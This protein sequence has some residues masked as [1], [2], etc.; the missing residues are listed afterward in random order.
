METE[1]TNQ[2]VN[3]FDALVDHI[4]RCHL[5][6]LHEVEDVCSDIKIKINARHSRTIDNLLAVKKKIEK[7]MEISMASKAVYIPKDN[8]LKGEKDI[9]L[10]KITE[11]KINTLHKLEMKLFLFIIDNCIIFNKQISSRIY[12]TAIVRCT[13]IPIKNISRQY[14]TLC[15]RNYLTIE[16]EKIRAGAWKILKLSNDIFADRFNIRKYLHLQLL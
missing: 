16:D 9:N 11:L 1:D 10:A 14:K 8:L 3:N 5:N 15:D 6:T 4:K 2:E 7:D 13:D 12:L